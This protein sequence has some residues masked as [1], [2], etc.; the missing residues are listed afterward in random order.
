[1]ED[2][3]SQPRFNPDVDDPEEIEEADVKA[4]QLQKMALSA[5]ALFEQLALETRKRRELYPQLVGEKSCMDALIDLMRIRYPDVVS[6][7]LGHYVN[8]LAISLERFTLFLNED[9]I[10]HSQKAQGEP[11][12][13][14]S[15][16]ASHDDVALLPRLGLV[17]NLCH[18]LV[19]NF[20]R[21]SPWFAI[22]KVAAVLDMNDFWQLG[23]GA[24]AIADNNN[25]PS[26]DWCLDASN[27]VTLK[28]LEQEQSEYFENLIAENYVLPFR[29]AT[30][31]GMNISLFVE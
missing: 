31:P 15:L 17:S 10:R 4:E 1:M 11:W 19:Y 25:L 8:E 21:R 20:G 3:S 13:L 23:F 16:K 7:Q 14:Y 30:N 27:W 12:D 6:P 5:A 29:C 22:D 24:Q 26:E 2:L 28:I 18:A 9:Q